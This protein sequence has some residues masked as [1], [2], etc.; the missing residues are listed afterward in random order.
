MDLHSESIWPDLLAKRK[1]QE[2]VSKTGRHELDAKQLN[3]AGTHLWKKLLRP[4]VLH[5]STMLA[6]P[7]VSND[8]HFKWKQIGS[9]V[10]ICWLDETTPAPTLSTSDSP[11][12]R[13]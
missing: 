1:Q 5:W 8:V 12:K 9:E 11:S 10:N 2:N 13:W 3:N 7:N 6:T 4:L